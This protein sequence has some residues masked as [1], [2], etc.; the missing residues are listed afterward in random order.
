MSWL[1]N[2]SIGKKLIMSITGIALILFLLFHASMNVTAVFSEDAY[3]TICALLGANWYAVAGT[4]ALGALVAIHFIYALILTLQNRKARGNDAYAVNVRPKNVEWAS[5]NMFVL[6][7]IV[8]GFM[9]LHFSQFWYKM[10]FTE[11][12]GHHE[13]ALGGEMVSPQ[14]GAAFIKYYFSQTWVVVA[15]LIW[16]VALWFHLSHGFWSA[17]QTIGW[18][19]HVWMN[20]WK[21]ISQVAATVICLAFAFVTIYFYARHMLCPF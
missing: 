13:V 11:L 4:I 21:V 2:S 20:R 17:I 15:Y 8:I 19:N 6:G 16:Y 1:L 14:D 3:N 5:Q 12:I 18:N 9:V 10:M 7:V